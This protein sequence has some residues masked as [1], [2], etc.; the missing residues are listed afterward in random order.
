MT[1]DDADG[2]DETRMNRKPSEALTVA[3]DSSPSPVAARRRHHSLVLTVLAILSFVALAPLVLMGWQVA[4]SLAQDLEANQKEI[5]LDKAKTLEGQITRYVQG[6]FDRLETMASAVSHFATPVLVVDGRRKVDA[7]AFRQLVEEYVEGKE[8]VLELTLV[9]GAPYDEAGS[10][11]VHSQSFDSEAIQ[12]ELAP[13]VAEA[14]EKGRRGLDYLSNPFLPRSPGMPLSLAVLSV[15]LSKL[16]VSPDQAKPVLVAVIKMEPVQS[17]VKS[18]GDTAFGYTVFVVDD[19]L[20]PF[21][22]TRF[23]EVIEGKGIVGSPLVEEFKTFNMSPTSLRFDQPMSGGKSRAM[24]GTYAPIAILDHRWGVFV[25]VE[26][27][28]ALFQVHDM[29]KTTVKW[30]LLAFASAIV[31]G[32][33]FTWRLTRPIHELADVSRRVA[34][35]DY[36]RRAKVHSNNEIGM[37]ADNFNIMAAEIGTTIH[38]LKLQKE[39]NDQ[40]FISSIRSLAA[41]IDARDPYTRGHSERVTRYARIIARQLKLA[42]D[43][44]RHVEIGALLHDVGKIGIEDRILRKPAALTPEEFEIMKTHPEKGGQIMEPISFL[45]DATEVIIHHHERW[46]GQGYPSGLRGEE[47]PIGARVVNVAD[48]FDAMTTNRPYQ[49]AMTFAV[50]AKKIGEFSGKACDPAVVLAFQH[51]FDAG[52]FVQMEGAQRVG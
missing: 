20:R 2:N 48:T 8:G 51:A 41:A 33:V 46:D 45:R 34:L 32:V 30:G 18:V 50:A 23:D 19:Q 22:H 25:E 10:I 14:V 38:D 13:L 21:A 43:Q 52:L 40:L 28:N 15:P 11:R 6:H 37:L 47:I 44:V 17:L 24:I 7:A 36:A 9:T 16:E 4:A 49:R 26:A 1:L 3:G 29:I 35:G 27:A 39:V 31:I 12:G 5:Q 42:P